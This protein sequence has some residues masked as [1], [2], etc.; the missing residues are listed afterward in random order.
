MSD[1]DRKRPANGEDSVA[2]RAAHPLH[3][4]S[5]DGPL[6]QQ[7]VVYFQKEAIWR[8]MHHYK[9]QVRLL[10]R[11]L[12][13]FKAQYE[14]SEAR[15]GVVDAWYLQLVET[16]GL[17][18]NGEGADEGVFVKLE[19]EVDTTLERRRRQLNQLVAPILQNTK[20]DVDA[21]LVLEKYEALS[22]EHAALKAEKDTLARLKEDLSNRLDT[23]QQELLVL[24]KEHD[25]AQLKTLQRIDERVKDEEPAGEPTPE[26]LAKPEEAEPLFKNEYEAVLI[27]VAELKAVNETLKK[28]LDEITT[29]YTAT[30]KENVSLENKLTELTEEDLRH[31]PAYAG[32]VEKSAALSTDLAESSR[33]KDK[34]A[35]KVGEL[36]ASTADIANIINQELAA[37]NK[38]LKEQ[39]NRLEQDLVRIRT[40]RDELLSKQTILKAEAE[41]KQTNDALQQLN[42]VLSQQ[43]DNLQ[44]ER[45]ADAAKFEDLDKPELL[46]RIGILSA[47][48]VEI[49]A[50]FQETRQVSL[51]KLDLAIDS[52]NLVKKL[53]IEKTKADQKYF[54]S[55]R[56][57]DSLSAEN[58]V[59]KSQ[60][61][62][63]QELIN[64][65]NDLEKTYLLKIDLL[66]KSVSDYKSI[67]EL[68]IRENSS[69]QEKL[70]HALSRRAGLEAE[71]KS[72]KAALADT[73]TANA[74]YE[75]QLQNNEIQVNRLESRLKHTENLLAKYKANNTAGLLAEDEKQLEA[76]RLIAKCS[77]CSKNWKDTAITVCGHVFCSGCTQERL[78]ARLRRCPSCNRGFSANDLL[79]IHL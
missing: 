46:K 48:M 18:K 79:S 37:D 28:Q 39:Q 6:T 3:E 74:D 43:L 41:N 59:L 27:E 77:V 60:V 42:K 49:E 11:D 20:L 58:K 55:M 71:L 34:L 67:R 44:R 35:A 66:T 32:L 63:S 76:L 16:F 21:K 19:N 61:A 36:E 78:A 38:R 7:D 15:L 52:D 75:A 64:K 2:K 22:Q 51:Q 8:Q 1:N 14:A 4:L 13:H 68:S 57:K 30:Q 54:A 47:E 29:K 69:L 9:T 72:V 65:L 62:K 26:A 10:T 17:D 12:S 53:T 70:K 50:A 24:L 73:K 23:L 40:A 31:V 45:T 25:R 33:L 5:D 56:V